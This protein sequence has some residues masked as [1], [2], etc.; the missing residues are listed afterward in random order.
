M[1]VECF[2]MYFGAKNSIEN[3]PYYMLAR[4]DTRHALN[5]YVYMETI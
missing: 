3:T 2:I 4:L 5:T 1:R